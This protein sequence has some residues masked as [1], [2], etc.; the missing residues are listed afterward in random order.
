MFVIGLQRALRSI[1]TMYYLR[2][3]AIDFFL[4]HPAGIEP[5]YPDY[6]SG[7]SPLML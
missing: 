7:A 1:N 4:E 3:Q 5:A 2:P 6:K